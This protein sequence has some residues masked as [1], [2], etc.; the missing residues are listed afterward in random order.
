MLHSPASSAHFEMH[1][2][3]LNEE[4]TALVRDEKGEPRNRANT[5]TRS[6]AA[7][8]SAK[9]SYRRKDPSAR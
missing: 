6:R 4:R 8:L 7:R 2:V 5:A 9:A 3:P 1:F